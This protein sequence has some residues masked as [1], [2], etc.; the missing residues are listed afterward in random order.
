MA[1]IRYEVDPHN[2]LVLDES[3]GKS[4]LRKF[5]KVIDGR[6]KI[7]GKNELSYH[8]KS[9]AADESIPHQLKLR[10][11]WSLTDNH[12]LQLTLDKQGRETFGD[13]VTLHGRILDVKA[14]SLLFAITT[15]TKDNIRSTYV[16]NLGGS[17]KADRNNRLSF[18]IKREMGEHD[19]L[20]FNGTW[21][22]NRNHRIV[23]RYEKAKFVRKKKKTHTL[24]FK[25]HWDIKK[26]LRLSYLLEG[27]TDSVFEFRTS[28]GIFK[29]GYIK[30]TLGIGLANRV[31]PVRRIVTLYGSW[32]LKRNVGLLFEVKY[33]NKKLHAIVFGAEARLTSRDTISFRL[34]NDIGN[35]NIGATLKLSHRILKGDGQAFL[36]LLKSK[37][38]FAIYA[39]AGWRW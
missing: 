33:E 22:I 37:R 24:T 8:I 2:R 35:K 9:P 39:G 31:N 26:R 15:K 14:N 34:K 30:Y 1:K 5:R 28:A 7:N 17:W 16:L 23:Y 12:D 19:I 13:K 3:G 18:H 20:T 38:E 6:F 25:G 32:K 10:G 4:E 36:R 27:R 29:K 21:E 11:K